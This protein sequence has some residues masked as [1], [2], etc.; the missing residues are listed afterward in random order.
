MSNALASCR[1][2]LAR[3]EKHRAELDREVARFR[4]SNPYRVRSKD[5]AQTSHT[6]HDIRPTRQVPPRWQAILGDCLH[7]YRSALDHMVWTLV[8]THGTRG[9][10]RQFPVAVSG[11]HFN[12][13]F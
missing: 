7:N 9:D 1:A 4:Q 12:S 8:C 10:Q 13:I 2:K 3:A 5:D 6:V 11:A